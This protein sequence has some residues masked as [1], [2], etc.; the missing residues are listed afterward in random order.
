MHLAE[1]SLFITLA[2]LL[3]AFHILPP[4][5]ESGREVPVDTSEDAFLLGS[6]I[7]AKPFRL[8]LLPRSEEIEGTIRS[9]WEMARKEGFVLGGNR[10]MVDGVSA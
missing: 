7:L 3:W 8:R 1:N 5:D 10:V 6:G 4:L 2:S 9:E